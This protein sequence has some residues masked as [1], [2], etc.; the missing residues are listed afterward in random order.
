MR[1][2]RRTLPKAKAK[3]ASAS[4][5]RRAGADDATPKLARMPSLR[6][7]DRRAQH[8]RGASRRWTR[9]PEP[10]APITNGA[11]KP[12]RRPAAPHRDPPTIAVPSIADEPDRLGEVA[13]LARGPKRRYANEAKSRVGRVP[14][15][16]E[17]SRLVGEAQRSSL[18]QLL[19]SREACDETRG[20]GCVGAKAEKRG[21]S[22]RASGELNDLSGSVSAIRCK[23]SAQRSTLQQAAAPKRD[24]EVTAAGLSAHAPMRSADSPGWSTGGRPLRWRKWRRV[25]RV[26]QTV[27]P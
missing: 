16:D 5:R 22:S 2:L 19:D 27:H 26:D 21:E 15:L 14:A 20:E 12:T 10:I 7:R 24:D 18:D 17:P 9:R 13:E 1:V 25:V 4:A 6:H 11:T 23:D 3:R 8:R